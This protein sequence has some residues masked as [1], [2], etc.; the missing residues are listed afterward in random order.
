MP[1]CSARV[2]YSKS[3]INNTKKGSNFK[4]SKA[5]IKMA[6]KILSN[7][8]TSII[9]RLDISFNIKDRDLDA[10]IGRTAHILFL[11]QEQIIRMI[12]HRYGHFFGDY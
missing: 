4:K 12:I 9:Y 11:D 6:T 7:L 3:I 1:F 2:Q 5:Y 8:K 10:F